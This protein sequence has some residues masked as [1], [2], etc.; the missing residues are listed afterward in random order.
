MKVALRIVT[1]ISITLEELELIRKLNCS[2]SSGCH[3]QKLE[4]GQYPR[5]VDLRH[6]SSAC[7]FYTAAR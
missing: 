4:E 5:G 7:G 6:T 1:V 3:R 2:R